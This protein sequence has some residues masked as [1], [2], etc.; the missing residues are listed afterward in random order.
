MAYM[1]PL[2][3][4][5]Q[6]SDEQLWQLFKSGNRGAFA[7]IYEDHADALFNY[8]MHFSRDEAT[9]KDG[10]QDLFVEIWNR[11]MHLGQTDNIR[12]YLMRSL[13]RKLSVFQKEQ[14]RMVLDASPVL[15]RLAGILNRRAL[16]QY[17]RQDESEEEVKNR[18][19]KAIEHL[20][21]RQKEAIFFIYFEKITYEE[22]ASI[23]NVNIK[24][25]YNL[26]WRGIELL[27]KQ[28]R[29]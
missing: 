24:T 21:L 6:L 19:T 15:A 17:N 5:N 23:M 3:K 20:P 26:V 14:N 12:F 9:V 22:A 7:R 28:L 4:F 8:G 18:I 10:I 25:V 13:R 27:R 2:E 1:I 11:R 16:D 29:R